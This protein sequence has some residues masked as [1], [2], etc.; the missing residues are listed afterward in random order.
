MNIAAL[1]SPVLR[2]EDVVYY[3]CKMYQC[4]ETTEKHD[5][6]VAYCYMYRKQENMYRKYVQKTCICTV[7]YSLLRC[8]NSVAQYVFLIFEIIGCTIS[9]D[10]FVVLRN[11]MTQ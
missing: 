8:L 2:Q 7:K 9:L 3:V 6:M 5:C 1:N 10:R 11:H 4:R